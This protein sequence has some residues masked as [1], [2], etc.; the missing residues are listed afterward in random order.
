MQDFEGPGLGMCQP[1]EGGKGYELFCD[2]SYCRERRRCRCPKQSEAEEK[3]KARWSSRTL[4]L[5][6][7]W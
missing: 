7:H 4:L 1:R 2:W 5:S 3:K 6:W